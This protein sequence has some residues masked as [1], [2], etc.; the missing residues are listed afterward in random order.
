MSTL[1]LSSDTLGGSVTLS[2]PT[3]ASNVTVTLPDTDG[4]L[5]TGGSNST[6]N[7]YATTVLIPN[8]YTGVARVGHSLYT[9]NN[10]AVLEVPVLNANSELVANIIPR[11]GTL[12]TLQTI[13]GSAGELASATDQGA[14]IKFKGTTPGGDVFYNTV[15]TTASIRLYE[16]IMNIPAIANAYITTYFPYNST[17]AALNNTVPD[18]IIRFIGDDNA[19]A[20]MVISCDGIN[21]G[22]VAVP[23]TLLNAGIVD[24]ANGM[25]LVPRTSGTTCYYWDKT[26]FVWTAYSTTVVSGAYS[27]PVSMGSV[28]ISRNGTSYII[29]DSANTLT[30]YTFSDSRYAL[31]TTI[32]DSESPFVVKRSPDNYAYTT[33]S[34]A[35]LAN[36]TELVSISTAGTITTVYTFVAPIPCNPALEVAIILF[37]DTANFVS[38]NYADRPAYINGAPIT[39]P[40]PAVGI[41]SVIIYG[42][43]A[44]ATHFYICYLYGGANYIYSTQDGITWNKYN[45]P[46][47]GIAITNIAISDAGLLLFP[48]VRPAILAINETT[49]VYGLRSSGTPTQKNTAVYRNMVVNTVTTPKMLIAPEIIYTR[50]VDN[51]TLIPVTG[52]T[53][54]TPCNTAKISVRPAGTIAA[55]TI[56]LPFAPYDGQQITYMF[57]QAITT[58]TFNPATSNISGSLVNGVSSFATSATANTC[59]LFIYDL[60]GKSWMLV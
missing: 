17:L 43:T 33:H 37:T 23:A 6:I 29:A 19:G 10:D 60:T 24:A 30:T 55:L 53:Y 34:D 20:Y 32:S 50:M 47:A 9:G 39:I 49:F 13:I 25:M 18:S 41:T 44:S 54:N 52:A 26:L 14:I 2:A 28:A 45:D 5:V 31:Y 22:F 21:W 11:T 48:A 27:R 57:T 8:P 56:N 46:S 3:T 36:I 15:K 4:M 16:N 58:L 12:A 35:A 7:T 59:K 51:A 42:A 40:L 1:K 38:S